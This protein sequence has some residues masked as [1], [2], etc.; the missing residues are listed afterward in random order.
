MLLLRFS[1]GHGCCNPDTTQHQ[2]HQELLSWRNLNMKLATHAGSVKMISCK[3]ANWKAH[4]AG[5]AV[6]AWLSFWHWQGSATNWIG[7][8]QFHS[9][10]ELQQNKN[11]RNTRNW[12][13]ISNTRNC[14]RIWEAA[15]LA[16][17]DKLMHHHCS[18]ANCMGLIGCISLLGSCFCLWWGLG[19]CFCL[20]RPHWQT[21]TGLN[22]RK[23]K[24]SVPQRRKRTNCMSAGLLLWVSS[25]HSVC[26]KFV[27]QE[28]SDYLQLSWH[29]H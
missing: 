24:A 6:P 22:A 19:S 3:K 21:N 25:H 26:N 27:L 13:H 15:S 28:S 1:R 10:S 9:M 2:I 4:W 5:T 16:S 23:R 18:L 11:T 8:V 29:D 12:K 17:V 7:R 14:S 20:W